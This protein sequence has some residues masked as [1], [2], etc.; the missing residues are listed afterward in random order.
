MILI[1]EGYDTNFYLKCC[2]LYPT[3]FVF[4]EKE[5]WSY[6]YY[7]FFFIAPSLIMPL[8]FSFEFSLGMKLCERRFGYL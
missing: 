1:F 6:P 5:S 2:Q 3:F 7:V 8:N 4:L